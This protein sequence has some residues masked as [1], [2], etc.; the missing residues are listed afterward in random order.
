MTVCTVPYFRE[1]DNSSY[2][3]RIISYIMVGEIH[4]IILND[5]RGVGC[6]CIYALQKNILCT[7]I[8]AHLSCFCAKIVW[9]KSY[10]GDRINNG[11]NAN[12]LRPMERQHRPLV[13]IAGPMI[14]KQITCSSDR[15]KPGS[16]VQGT[17]GSPERD[18]SEIHRLFGRLSASVDG[19]GL[20]RRIL[21]GEP[22]GNRIA[23]LMG[24]FSGFASAAS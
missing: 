9:K 12:D 22:S 11:K 7:C 18:L 19:A 20:L 14:R 16:T 21:P 15:T 3:Y 10:A 23:G 6:G 8:G 13:S 17:D 4:I 2:F 1:Y 24:N 5:R